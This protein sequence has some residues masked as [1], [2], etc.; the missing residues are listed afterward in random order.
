MLPTIGHQGNC[1]TISLRGP[2]SC[3][4]KTL[5]RC[6]D[7]RSPQRN[8]AIDIWASTPSP[9]TIERFIRSGNARQNGTGKANQRTSISSLTWKDF[10]QKILKSMLD[11]DNVIVE[12]RR[13]EKEK[14]EG[15]YSYILREAKRTYIPYRKMSIRRNYHLLLLKMAF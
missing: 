10:G 1:M 14:K 11:G 9:K 5:G 6:C 12:A 13:E 7:Q 2:Y 15:S 3:H 4:E 8:L